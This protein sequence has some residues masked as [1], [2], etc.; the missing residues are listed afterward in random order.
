MRD[1]KVRIPRGT[2]IRLQVT[3]RQWVRIVGA[4][5]AG[6]AV[7]LFLSWL[8]GGI[9]ALTNWRT[10]VSAVITCI[11]A[12]VPCVWYFEDINPVVIEGD[13]KDSSSHVHQSADLH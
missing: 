3:R 9:A 7:G 13:K 8:F 5:V 11:V 10:Y 4:G 6:F 1:E 2:R 12:V